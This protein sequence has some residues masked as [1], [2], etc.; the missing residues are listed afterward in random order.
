[1]LADYAAVYGFQATTFLRARDVSTIDADV[2]RTG[3]NADACGAIAD[4]YWIRF[5]IS[6]CVF[7]GQRRSR[8]PLD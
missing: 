2:S 3:A 6:P 5:G 8:Y 1:M 4:G 7:K